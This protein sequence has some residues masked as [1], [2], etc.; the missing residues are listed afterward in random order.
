M[1]SHPHPHHA[2]KRQSGTG[3]GT[4][5]VAACVVDLNGRVPT[6]IQL[7]PA[8]R[9]RARDG[10][11]FD[12]P[13]GWLIDAGIAERV[14]A[15]ALATAGDFVIDYE[16]QTLHASEN[17]QP[18][19]ASGWF[20][21]AGLQW[22]EDQGLFATGIEWTEAA[23]AAITAKEYRYISPV[24][25]YD[26]T[27]GHV[28]AILMAAL[29]NFPAIEGL[30]DLTAM[31]AARFS[32][33]GALPPGAP[34]YR[35]SMDITEQPE[36][37]NPVKR[38]QLIQL[39]GLAANATDEQIE[40]GLVALKAEASAASALRSNL[41]LADD[42]DVVAAVAALKA[43][44]NQ[45]P[46]PSKYVPIEAFEAL[47][48]EVAT[49]KTE[50]TKKDVDELVEVGLS[51][52]KLHPDQEAWARQYGEADIVGLKAYLEKTPAIAALKSTQTQGKPPGTDAEGELDADS[53]ALCAQM[54][55]DPEEYKKTLAGG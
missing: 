49:L 12:V 11:P 46:D 53:A 45:T 22:R 29:T 41:Q 28:L 4:V 42:A 19:P 39:L 9:F 34:E 23:K 1:Y 26:K 7:T 21:G 6:E 5:A 31:A 33:T 40:A 13:T 55:I 20:K 50:N 43:T 10:R 48:G 52:G 38:E 25:A 37:E 30:S 24:I 17:G 16:H 47:K 2:F 51:S 3:T 44:T 14:I 35:P 15:T 27:T 32:L 8:G 18:A 54:G 36:E